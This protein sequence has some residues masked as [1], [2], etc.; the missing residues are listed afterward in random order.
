MRVVL[1]AYADRSYEF[2]LKPPPTSWF[3]KKFIGKTK[4]TNLT[5]HVFIDR[6]AANAIY[7]IA[8]MKKEMD[9]DFAE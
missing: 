3:I 8:V 5:G 1:K 2:K 4:C 7:E 6:I 9:P